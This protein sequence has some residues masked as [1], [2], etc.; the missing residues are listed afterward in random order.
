MTSI[1]TWNA[2]GLCNEAAQRSVKELIRFSRANIILI[3]ETK[4]QEGRIIEY[5]SMWGESWKWHWIPSSG[6][7]GG[8]ITA[9]NEDM[10]QVDDVLKGAHTISIS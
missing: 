10:V 3:Q 9:W 1:V 2:R 8:L 5:A 6:L 7:S 4:I